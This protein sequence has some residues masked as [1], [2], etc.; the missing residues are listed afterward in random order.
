MYTQVALTKDTD[1]HSYSHELSYPPHQTVEI[2]PK[3]TKGPVKF[4]VRLL[5][6][7]S[8][9][10]KSHHF[11]PYAPAKCEIFILHHAIALCITVVTTETSGL[12]S[13][14]LYRH[15]KS[16]PSGSS[17]A[18]LFPTDPFTS[19]RP[20]LETDH[21]QV[22]SS[23]PPCPNGQVHEETRNTKFFIGDGSQLTESTL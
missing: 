7:H 6:S 23:S 4:T 5:D 8:V 21:Q 11:I 15:S 17:S 14:R 20:P 16:L 1:K 10:L 2:L 13:N 18:P 22:K 19:L 12:Q 9:E 3:Q